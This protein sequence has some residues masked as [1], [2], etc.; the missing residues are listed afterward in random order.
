MFYAEPTRGDSGQAGRLR[1]HSTLLGAE[2][3]TQN[4]REIEEPGVRCF[5][6]RA[7]RLRADRVFPYRRGRL[8]ALLRRPYA[9]I[10]SLGNRVELRAMSRVEKPA[11]GG[12]RSFASSLP[13]NP[14]AR[15]YKTA[16]SLVDNPDRLKG[17]WWRCVGASV[18]D[19][20]GQR[21]PTTS[22]HRCAYAERRK[23]QETSQTVSALA[24][25]S[26]LSGRSRNQDGF[27]SAPPPQRRADTGRKLQARRCARAYRATKGFRRLA[28]AQI[29]SPR[30]DR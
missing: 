28:G 21:P 5:R 20:K 17:E 12:N 13:G 30:H 29:R 24:S 25:R 10:K 22:K 14:I 11:G 18:Q 15:D 3:Y 4:Q 27:A 23:P 19:R 26:V 7:S 9:K 1:G 16:L 6:N 2:G 8:C